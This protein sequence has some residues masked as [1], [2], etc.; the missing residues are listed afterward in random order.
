M[1]S[2]YEQHDSLLIRHLLHKDCLDATKCSSL[3]FHD[4]SMHS[5]LRIEIHITL[6]EFYSD[7]V[8]QGRIDFRWSRAKL[9]N[10]THTSGETDS[11]IMLCQIESRKQ[12]SWEQRAN[13]R[14]SHPAD[15]LALLY[16]REETLN[17][18]L[19]D[20]QLGLF[21]LMRLCADRIPL[22]LMHLNPP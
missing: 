11:P 1:E 21:F 22:H 14:L 12:I 17:A 20:V 2:L 7:R 15:N 16:Q 19:C 3:D 5:A 10:L 8:D 4:L 6:V 13:C 18:A 9:Y